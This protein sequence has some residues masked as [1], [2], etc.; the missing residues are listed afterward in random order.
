MDKL[1]KLVNDY[2]ENTYTQ[3]ELIDT[4]VKDIKR[5]QQEI[6]ENFNKLFK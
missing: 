4:M 6:L 3:L 5:D 2:I 1:Q